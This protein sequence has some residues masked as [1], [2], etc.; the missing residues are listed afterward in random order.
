MT[1]A[2]RV[3]EKAAI[4]EHSDANGR[5]GQ[6]FDRMEGGMSHVRGNMVSMSGVFTAPRSTKETTDVT[7]PRSEK[8]R[9]SI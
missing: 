1:A 5:G 2:Y 6:R 9:R 7:R 4:P 3:E 8:E